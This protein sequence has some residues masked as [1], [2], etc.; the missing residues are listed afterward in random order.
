MNTI[1]QHLAQAKILRNAGRN[2]EASAICNQILH[3]QPNNWE[4]IYL[5]ALIALGAGKYPTALEL[6]KRAEAMTQSPDVFNSLGEALRGL[7]RNAEAIIQ[8]RRAMA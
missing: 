1:A 8:Y 2:A 4:A 3:Q 6:L 7:G 5:L